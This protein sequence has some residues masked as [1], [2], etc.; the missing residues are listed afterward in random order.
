[1]ERSEGNSRVLRLKGCCIANPTTRVL[2]GMVH[3]MQRMTG[4]SVNPCHLAGSTVVLS[5]ERIHLQGDITHLFHS[6][7]G[8]TWHTHGR[9]QG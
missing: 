3:I 5:I 6:V 7:V 4:D 2:W 1:M 8:Q 9:I